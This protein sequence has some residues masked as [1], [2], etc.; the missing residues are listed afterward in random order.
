MP[1]ERSEYGMVLAFF[2]LSF[3]TLAVQLFR[4]AWE[5]G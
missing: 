1:P 5:R 2:P 4:E 3:P